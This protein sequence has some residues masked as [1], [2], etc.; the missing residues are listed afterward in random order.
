MTPS[1]SW[2]RRLFAAI[3][4]LGAAFAVSRAQDSPKPPMHHAIPKPHNLQVL[5][6]DI[7]VPDLL[8]LMHGYSAQ[9]GVHCNYCHAADPATHRMDF[10][11]DAKPEKTT[12][13][14]MIVMTDTINAKFLSQ[15]KAQG[16]APVSK[17]ECGTC[18]RGEAM[19][20]AYVPPPEPEHSH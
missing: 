8:K 14:M 7:S 19:P 1:T 15:I 16:T 3:A 10:A 18:H 9:L 12:A 2:N 17:V 20:P 13:R 5:P 4:L 6:K 11:S